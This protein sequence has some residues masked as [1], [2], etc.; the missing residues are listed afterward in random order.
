VR[1]KDG[2]TAS[3]IFQLWL[4]GIQI[5]GSKRITPADPIQDFSVSVAN[6]TSLELRVTDAGDGNNNDHAVWLDV[7]L[8]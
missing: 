6:G 5:W 8:D 2:T 3:V 1:D 4:D 7:K